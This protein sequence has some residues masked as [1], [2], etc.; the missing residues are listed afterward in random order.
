MKRG[1]ESN[2][3]MKKR[4][5]TLNYRKRSLESNSKSEKRKTF[6]KSFKIVRSGPKSR[7]IFQSIK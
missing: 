1:L 6:Y 4:G 5:I 7:V 2:N 3:N